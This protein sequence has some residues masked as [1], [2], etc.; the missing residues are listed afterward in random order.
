MVTA[1]VQT[2]GYRLLSASSKRGWTATVRE[3]VFGWDWEELFGVEA[4]I[5]Q[6][7]MISG[8][9]YKT[10]AAKRQR[11]LRPM[12]RLHLASSFSLALAVEWLAVNVE[13]YLDGQPWLERN[14]PTE[15][16]SRNVRS[17]LLNR[18]HP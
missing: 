11:S 10:S 1:A 7:F 4:M 8:Q 13:R 16:K 17:T 14:A 2:L 9:N 12:Q 3:E 15:Q 18:R 6:V 5:I